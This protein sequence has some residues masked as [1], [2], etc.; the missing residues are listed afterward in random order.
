[1]G[2]VLVGTS[3]FVYQ[4]WKGLFYPPE[5]P[6]RLWLHRFVAEF[7][8]VELNNTFYR[9]PLPQAVER[10]R[11]E[12]PRDFVFAAKGSRF[13]THMKRLLD[14]AEGL[15]RYFAPVSLLGPK[16]AVVLWQLPPRWRADPA[17]LDAFLHAVPRRLRRF[18]L[19]HAVEFRDESW[20]S[21]AVCDVLDRHG[22]AFCEHDIIGRP[23][24]RLTGDFRYVRF[25][26]ATGKYQGRYGAEA[27][28]PFAEDL[29]RWSRRRDA[30]VYFNND[31]GG[32][33]IADARDLRRLLGDAPATAYDVEAALGAEG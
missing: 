12:T 2:R 13:T 8:T 27:L 28:E 6:Q 19:R 26:G 15:E 18:P 7:P 3:G 33:A 17:R 9:L 21:E 24:P 31:I 10:W 4:H 22:A 20:Y 16:L 14:P 11:R 29:G 23:P 1:M 30:Y 25:H 5:L 32:H